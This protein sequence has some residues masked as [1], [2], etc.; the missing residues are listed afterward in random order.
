MIYSSRG[1]IGTIVFHLLVLFVLLFFGFSFPD[2]P[3]A[4]QG[5]MVNFGTDLTGLGDV[6]PSGSI[7]QGGTEEDTKPIPEETVKVQKAVPVKQKTKP[8]P[9]ITKAQEIEETKVKVHQPTEEEI[10]QAEQQ[11][12][13]AEEQVKKKAEDERQARITEQWNSKGQSAFS[14]KGIGTTEGSQGITEGTGN[15]GNPNGVANSDNYG[16]G[17][18]LGNG[19][20]GYSMGDRGLRGDL[21]KP[22]VAGCTVTSRNII[23]VQILVNRDG[24]VEGEPKIL[25]A[26]YQDDCIYKAVLEAAAEAKFTADQQAPVRQ[27]GWIRYIIEP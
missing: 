17:G 3:P 4:E 16:P 5:V 23:K 11:K 21:P 15:Q 10:K 27:Q 8:A 9:V 20:V 14:K 13:V 18:G 24:N 6:E 25:D 2:P 22:I 7:I 12:I 1:L 26:K 19:T